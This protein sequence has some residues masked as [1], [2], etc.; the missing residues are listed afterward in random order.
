MENYIT[1]IRG[2]HLCPPIQSCS[3]GK[4]R[5]LCKFAL[6]V[7]HLNTAPCFRQEEV[8][9]LFTEG[10][11]GDWRRWQQPK[12]EQRRWASP[13]T[14]GMLLRAVQVEESPQWLCQD[15]EHTCGVCF[16]KRPYGAVSSGL[17]TV[18]TFFLNSL[19]EMAPLEERTGCV[20]HLQDLHQV[21]KATG[22]LP[23]GWETEAQ[24]LTD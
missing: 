14:P 16:C 21:G 11:L 24:Q 10:K 3:T 20:G 4:V 8:I 13:L 5:L 7:F 9:K 2:L 1:L 18:D 19:K 22:Q 12:G 17:L 6:E 23:G 15:G